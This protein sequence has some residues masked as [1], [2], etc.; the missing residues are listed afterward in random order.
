MTREPPVRSIALAA[1]VVCG[2][3][4]MHIDDDQSYFDLHLVK[5]FFDAGTCHRLISELQHSPSKLAPSYG[6]GE[7]PLVDE[8]TRRTV[9]VLPAA[10]T[11]AM[12]HGRLEE[13]AAELEQRF[14]ISLSGFEAPQFLRYRVGDFFVAHQDGHTGLVKLKSDQWRRVSV[15]IFLNSE[16]EASS[17]HTYGG[18]SLVFSDWRSNKRFRL[19]AEAGTLVAFLAETTHE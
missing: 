18:G 2:F 3:A 16:S 10:E 9:Q 15:S 6:K 12:V 17:P 4:E 7:A 8:R 5:D 11:V 13:Y 1:S 19:Q 14:D